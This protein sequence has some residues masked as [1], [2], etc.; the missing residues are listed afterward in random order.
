VNSHQISRFEVFVVKP[1][2]E[3][4]HDSTEEAESSPL[5]VKKDIL[6]PDKATR[7]RR[8][9]LLMSFAFSLNHGAVVACL[10]YAAA[11]LGN[12]LGS[13]SSGI[14]YVCYSLT[15]LVGSKPF[16][17]MVGPKKALLAGVTG[18]PRSLFLNSL[19][20]SKCLR[21]LITKF[22][23]YEKATIIEHL[24]L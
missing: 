6:E 9:F 4:L 13:A 2:K 14:L 24:V 15:A 23:N 8:N 21:S 19:C 11:E 22:I 5:V 20:V 7:L 1:H 18:A 12:E 16:V 3:M 17:S 10:A